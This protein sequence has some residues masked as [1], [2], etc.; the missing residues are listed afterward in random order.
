MAPG[1]IVAVVLQWGLDLPIE[2]TLLRRPWR[3]GHRGFNGDSIR[4]PVP[5]TLED[6]DDRRLLIE[7]DHADL[8]V[9]AKG[10]QEI[11]VAGGTVNLDLHMSWQAARR[12]LAL[13]HDRHDVLHMLAE[14]VSGA[15]WNALHD[16]LPEGEW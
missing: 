12:L 4:I 16:D 2:E 8:L 15:V 5:G 3:R 10:R 13:G 14:V 7:A 6:P 11:K 9:G 1:W